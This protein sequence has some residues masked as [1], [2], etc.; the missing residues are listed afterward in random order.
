VIENLIIFNQAC[1]LLCFAGYTLDI[2]R[3][4]NSFTIVVHKFYIV[5][6]LY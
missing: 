4:L 5:V 6:T 2:L 3:S 1:V